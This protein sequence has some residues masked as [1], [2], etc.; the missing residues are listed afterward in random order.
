MIR[1]HLGFDNY[2]KSL[3]PGSGKVCG[4]KENVNVVKGSR[5]I[6]CRNPWFREF[7]TSHF[8]CRFSN[9]NNTGQNSSV[10]DCKLNDRIVDYEQEG[11]VPFVGKYSI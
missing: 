6:N 1:F 11:L 2:F 3:R 7:W 4:S 9:A 10:P 8:K 5:V